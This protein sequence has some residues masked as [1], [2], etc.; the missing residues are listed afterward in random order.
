MG[1]QF[2]FS[3][4]ALPSFDDRGRSYYRIHGIDRAVTGSRHLFFSSDIEMARDFANEALTLAEGEWISTGT[5]RNSLYLEP[6]SQL[7]RIRDL[8]LLVDFEGAL[9][10]KVMCARSGKK[11]KIFR[12]VLLNSRDRTRQLIEIGAPA[13]LPEN[14]R[15]YWNVEALEDRTSLHDIS[16]VTQTAPG[17][18][19]RLMVLLR[20]YGR[21]ADA[22]AIL[23]RFA[24]AGQSD[25]F[26][27]AILDHIH[28]LLLDTTPD[29]RAEYGE[30]WQDGLN[31][32]I[33]LSTNLGGGGNAGHM[34]AL[35][36]E[37][38]REAINAPT[39]LLILDDDL[40]VSAES[41]ARY[42]MFC[43]YR[44]H[45]S[46]ISAPVLMKSRPTT[47]WE[48]GGFWGRL[49]FHEGGGFHQ[50]R[51]LFPN[52]LKHG[53]QVDSFDGLDTFCPLNPCEYS[54][55]IFFGLPM[56]V[57]RKLGYP[58]SF[59]LRG[60]DIEYSLRAQRHDIPLVTN[61]NITV[62][63]EPS[64]SYGQEYMAI[65]HGVIINLTYSSQG[66]EF[67]RRFF[68]ERLYEHASIEDEIGINLYRD[69]LAELT[70]PESLVLSN[71]FEKHYLAKLKEFAAIKML[72]IQDNERV[73]FEQ[74]AKERNI[75]LVPFVYPGYN[76]DASNCQSVV[77]FN[78]AMR[79]YREIPAI[80][81]GQKTLLIRQYVESLCDF[82]TRFEQIREFWQERLATTWH[83]DYWQFIRESHRAETHI[84]FTAT[85]PSAD[86]GGT[87]TTLSVL[88]RRGK[89][90]PKSHSWLG[91][92]R[93]AVEKAPVPSEILNLGKR[94][95]SQA[96][97]ADEL[98]AD[99]DPAVYLHI[100]QDVVNS[101]ID[102]TDHYLRFG[103]REGRRYKLGR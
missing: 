4:R 64:H 43:A 79:S 51:N 77:V 53:Q 44:S 6:L 88:P 102:P 25:P 33:V 66:A 73:T 52:L 100:N 89:G 94:D 40:S 57:F 50:K 28:F 7:T 58:A 55:F 90:S 26:Y 5:L 86:E 101:G 84:I 32:E 27:D 75:L 21:T 24:D 62:W 63:H 95:A 11:P 12:E 1:K 23:R 20:T 42:L 34:L 17:V 29:S 38:C 16:Y 13:D 93:A 72:R 2:Q 36:A 22:K 37:D 76:K 41:L 82:E 48:D 9:T 97:L 31:L 71:N 83:S 46:I 47:V 91:K 39:D 8:N 65:L 103:R 98:P 15:L 3:Q 35:L 14:S 54:T 18:D 68:E 96:K 30:D 56:A 92:L 85:R 70:N 19:S 61:P 80:P 45:D 74:Q 69:I 78:Q 10:V 60:D 87:S 81:P 99:F 67:Y 59:F 49:N